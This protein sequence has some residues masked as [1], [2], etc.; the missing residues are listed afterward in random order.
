MIRY[1][2]TATIATNLDGRPLRNSDEKTVRIRIQ[3]GGKGRYISTGIPLTKQQYE[4]SF[5]KNAKKPRDG[6]KENLILAEIEHIYNTVRKLEDELGKAPSYE[7][8]KKNASLRRDDENILTLSFLFEDYLGSMEEKGNYQRTKMVISIKNSLEAN[9]LI[10]KKT[11]SITS[12]DIQI[13]LQKLMDEGKTTNTIIFYARTLSTV[14]NS[15]IQKK[16]IKYNPV[17]EVKIPTRQ[18]VTKKIDEETLR[19]LL[20]ATQEETGLKPKDYILLQYFRVCFWAGGANI[21]D[22]LS[23]KYDNIIENEIVFKRRKTINKTESVIHIPLTK[24]LLETIEKLPKG[25]NHLFLPLDGA[26]PNTKE[27]NEIIFNIRRQINTALKRI[28][29]NKGFNKVTFSYARH[30]YPTIMARTGAN[31]K[32]ISSGMGHVTSETT[33]VFYMEDFTSEQRK[34]ETEKMETYLFGK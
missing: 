26:K 19:F 27:E 5:G 32:M 12:K 3:T 28:C 23:W 29:E 2:K 13:W 7:M 9:K 18:H 1:T 10:N 20:S 15:A 16:L 24:Q 25:K 17:T 4:A 31:L 11:D 30:M 22:I 14:F 34:S 21:A 8:I 6:E 33:E